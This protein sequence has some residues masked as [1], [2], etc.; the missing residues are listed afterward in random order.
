[1]VAC[2][3]AQGLYFVFIL[4]ISHFIQNQFL[5]QNKQFFRKKVELAENELQVSEDG[6]LTIY[7]HQFDTDGFFIC[8]LKKQ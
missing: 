3:R 1:M 5:E 2:F 6:S 8:R 4:H 7:P